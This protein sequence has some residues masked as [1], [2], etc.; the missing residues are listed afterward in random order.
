MIIPLL[1]F[2]YTDYVFREVVWITDFNYQ[3][4]IRLIK[5]NNQLNSRN[6][7]NNIIYVLLNNHYYLTKNYFPIASNGKF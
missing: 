7:F 2:Y 6:Y 4:E 3:F 5:Y 1:I